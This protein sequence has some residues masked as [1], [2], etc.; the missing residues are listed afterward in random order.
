MLAETVVKRKEGADTVAGVQKAVYETF[1]DA[2][3]GD[4]NYFYYS[5]HGVQ[6]GSGGAKE[7]TLFWRKANI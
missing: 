1:K 5:G 6:K 4:I 2:E 7:S 3:D